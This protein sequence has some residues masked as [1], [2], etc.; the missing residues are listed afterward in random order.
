MVAP[1]AS[2]CNSSHGEVR[3]PATADARPFLSPVDARRVS[4][5][6]WLCQVVP[7]MLAGPNQYGNGQ[8]PEWQ[9]VVE[10]AY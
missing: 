2:R 9:F 3:W 5:S 6:L 8:A 10:R 4:S 1:F 7:M